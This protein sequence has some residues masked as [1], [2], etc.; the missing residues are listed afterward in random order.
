MFNYNK[1]TL[2]ANRKKLRNNLTP[3]EAALWE[4]IKN[5]KLDGRKFRRQHSI[6]NFIL[7]FYCPEEKLAIELDGEDHYWDEGM[8]RD[9]IKTSYIKSHGIEILRFENMLVFKD[10]EF[11]LNTIKTKFRDTTPLSSPPRRG[12]GAPPILGG[13]LIVYL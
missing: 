12:L 11:V 5:K 6:G 3:A 4:L 8:K 13:E 1:K 9:K 2:E 10:Q 7:D